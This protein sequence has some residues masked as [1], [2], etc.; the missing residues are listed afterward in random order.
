MD[1]YEAMA[2]RRTIRDFDDRLIARDVLLRILD[3]GLKAPSHNH[4]R[5]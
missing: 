2:T 4:L 5:E 1:V 3:A